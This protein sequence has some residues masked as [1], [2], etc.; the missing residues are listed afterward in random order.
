[1]CVVNTRWTSG[2]VPRTIGPSRVIFE[3]LMNQYVISSEHP[4]DLPV[5]VIDQVGIIG[6]LLSEKLSQEFL[7]IFVHGQAHSSGNNIIQLPYR[8]KMPSISDSLFSYIFVISDEEN[9]ILGHVKRLYPV[10][11]VTK[12]PFIVIIP[13]QIA[14]EAFLK[15]LRKLASR[16]TVM[17]Y[18]D[19]FGGN[20]DMSIADTYMQAAYENR[21]VALS[22]N[23]TEK[24]YPIFLGDVIAGIIRGVF[25]EEHSGE[26]F[27]LMPDFYVTD[28]SFVRMMQQELPELRVFTRKK[29]RR[30]DHYHIP[31]GIPIYSPY[32]IEQAVKTAIAYWPKRAFPIRKSMYVPSKLVQFKTFTKRM[33][34]L[35]GIL[36]LCTLGIG[37]LGYLSATGVT[38]L[39]RESSLRSPSSLR[40]A[41]VSLSLAEQATKNTASVLGMV[42]AETVVSPLSS[43]IT[44]LQKLVQIELLMHEVRDEFSAY[45]EN[46][47]AT[48]ETLSLLTTKIKRLYTTYKIA[49]AEK[50]ITSTLKQQYH[51]EIAFLEK[52]I[53]FI[54]VFPT[55]LGVRTP[56]E[57]L[58]LL[59]N[60]AQL[61][62]GGGVVELYALMT[63]ERG[64]V[65]GFEIKDA[66]TL[67]SA[68]T[69]EIAVPAVLATHMAKKKL[70]LRDS[71]SA[72]GFQE[73]MK[74]VNL[75]HYLSTNRRVDGIISL[76]TTFLR[77]LLQTIG[78]VQLP[79]NTKLSADSIS[80]Q[81]TGKFTNKT[82]LLSTEKVTFFRNFHTAVLKQLKA[83]QDTTK[84]FSL[85]SQVLAERHLLLYSE[86]P[87]INQLLLVSDFATTIQE[88]RLKSDA[89][90]NDV[91]SL[92]E[93]NLYEQNSAH[94]RQVNHKVRI[95]ETGD[96]EEILAVTYSGALTDTT[97][98]TELVVPGAAEIQGVTVD[99]VEQRLLTLGSKVPIARRGVTPPASLVLEKRTVG[100][101]QVVGFVLSLSKSAS[102]T[103][104]ISYHVS[105]ALDMADS[106]IYEYLLLKQP[107]LTDGVLHVAIDYPK[108]LHVLRKSASTEEL[109][110]Q[111]LYTGSL[112]TDQQFQLVFSPK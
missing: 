100:E 60:N 1:M 82:A 71:T 101:R 36:L 41:A 22:T 8:H 61:R 111:I 21:Q 57:Y 16:S 29:T 69:E 73:A 80:Q 38:H 47:D 35:A 23:G 37:L 2:S 95:S 109:D 10:S 81:V 99:G 39:K 58:V 14:S 66:T 105:R 34:V 5:L 68:A 42:R 90:Y 63:T 33:L 15:K 67:S 4:H 74:Q 26:V 9:E 96:I 48:S 75:V 93:T 6:R 83:K 70:V 27:L 65:T 110:Q 98:Y 30:T 88:K 49:E 17:I 18:G 72:V 94:T 56:K 102:R 13:S 97:L 46:A 25:A 50:S 20:A 55:L 32:D 85:L 44:S 79:D 43:K 103:V 108:N 92:A 112:K 78:P 104:E 54:D 106:F 53:Q 91:A 52:N 87:H 76:D 24:S 12:S 59:T 107:G 28:I 86:E 3:V 7:T 19:I 77:L 84:L 62:G 89:V 64:R 11:Q 31:A 51:S 45:V 40:V